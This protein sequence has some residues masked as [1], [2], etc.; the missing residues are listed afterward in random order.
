M[1][2][3]TNPLRAYLS[4]AWATASNLPGGQFS[5]RSSRHA[6]LLSIPYKFREIEA[7]KADHFTSAA[8]GMLL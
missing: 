1:V 8:W 3:S 5:I 4:P 6:G 7:G 2:S